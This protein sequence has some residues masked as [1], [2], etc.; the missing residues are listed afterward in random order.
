M[1]ECL[2]LY[3]AD[4][5]IGRL[6]IEFT[7]TWGHFDATMRKRERASLIARATEILYCGLLPSL[8][9]GRAYMIQDET[10]HLLT[11]HLQPGRRTLK[12]V[13]GWRARL[14]TYQFAGECDSEFLSR[15]L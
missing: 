5:Q 6:S 13:P 11:H 2:Q 3:L 1:A 15:R 14:R 7:V 10:R 4:P 12:F 8:K 9:R